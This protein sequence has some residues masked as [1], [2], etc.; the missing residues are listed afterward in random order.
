MTSRSWVLDHL[1]GNLVQKMAAH[2]GDTMM[3]PTQPG[4]GIFSIV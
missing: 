3:M 4:S 2:I 1:V